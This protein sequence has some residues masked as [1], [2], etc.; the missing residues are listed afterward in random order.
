MNSVKYS[1]NVKRKKN[2][3]KTFIWKHREMLQT[4]QIKALF[5]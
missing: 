2:V 4:A 1:E 5:H 3:L